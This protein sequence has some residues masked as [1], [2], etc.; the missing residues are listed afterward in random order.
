MLLLSHAV[1]VFDMKPFDDFDQEELARIAVAD[2]MRRMHHGLLGRSHDVGALEDLAS[3]L[4][5][6]ADRLE[7]GG[8]RTPKEQRWHR[9]DDRAMPADGEEFAN[10]IDRPVSGRGNPWSVPM[11]AF[12]QG[13]DA[14]TTVN[15]GPGFE[16]APNRAH[17]GV[18]TAI[19]DDLCGFLLMLEQVTAFTAYL[20]VDFQ[21]PT[22][23]GADITY[24]ARV[25][26]RDGRKIYMTGE[27]L[28]E[29]QVITTCEG[30]FLSASL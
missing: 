20:K 29:D 8:I 16:G 22:P 10:A 25:T 5:E 30:L 13:L 9:P 27:C 6:E 2:Q 23:L 21:G 11:R 4:G 24:R 28:A 12:R 19:Y 17:G 18:V 14:V 7:S 15:L 26:E 3:R 1:R